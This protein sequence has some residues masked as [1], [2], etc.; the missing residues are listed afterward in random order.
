MSIGAM[1]GAFLISQK[2]VREALIIWIITNSFELFVTFHYYHNYWLSI[3]WIFFLCNAVYG[4]YR[5]RKK[6]NE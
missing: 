4:I 2:M 6:E 1:L 5:W 3:Q